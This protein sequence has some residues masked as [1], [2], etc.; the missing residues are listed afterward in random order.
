V[1]QLLE[2][3]NLPPQEIDFNEH[4]VDINKYRFNKTSQNLMGSTCPVAPKFHATF[5]QPI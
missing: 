1:R 4:I 3:E 2:A 5:G